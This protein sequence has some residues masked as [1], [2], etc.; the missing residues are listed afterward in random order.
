MPSSY[1]SY[2]P[3]VYVPP[4]Q[5]PAHPAASST[6]GSAG[7][8]S[9]PPPA[10]TSTPGFAQALDLPPP[11]Q[12]HYQPSAPPEA[13]ASAPSRPYGSSYHPPPIKNGA[14]ASSALN[15]SVYTSGPSGGLMSGGNPSICHKIDYELK[16]NDMQLVEI[17]LDPQETVIAE[18][19]AMMYMDDGIA[20]ETKFGDGG[21][22]NQK[23]WKQLMSAGG[24]LLTGESL[25]IT[26]FTNRGRD[27]AR[28]AFAAPFP[29]MLFHV[30]GVCVYL[31]AD[32]KNTNCVH[33]KFSFFMVQ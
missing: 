21:K 27:K 18:A 5:A 14:V 3:S 29:G 33:I 1:E 22:P 10:A 23:F 24:R 32:C 8:T 28:V 7:Q 20:F 6:S 12:Q 4:G 2:S 30:I 9:S 25:F 31:Y 17:E 11:S 26:H 16:G 13:Y 19:G 15:S